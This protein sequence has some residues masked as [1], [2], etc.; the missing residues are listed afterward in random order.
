MKPSDHGKSD[1]RTALE[2]AEILYVDAAT[3]AD[4]TPATLTQ[5]DPSLR[6]GPLT[7]ADTHTIGVA[8]TDHKVVL[9]TRGENQPH[10]WYCIAAVDRAPPTFGHGTRLNDVDS[11]AKCS[12]PSW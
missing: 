12:D 7:A 6:F 9:V 8:V 10:D 2:D 4:L 3:Y 11:F 1:L 5:L